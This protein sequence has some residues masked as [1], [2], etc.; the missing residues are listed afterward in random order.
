MK[1]ILKKISWLNIIIFLILGLIISGLCIIFRSP[2]TTTSTKDALKYWSDIT[3]IPAIIEYGIIALNFSAHHGTFD[4]LTY[5]F[6]YI[7]CKFIPM[8][9]IDEEISGTYADY[10]EIRKEKRKTIPYE[11]LIVATIFLIVAISCFIAY[12]QV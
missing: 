8:P 6:K 10:K 1:N 2:F 4:G 3:L 9:K 11:G 12:Y 5:S 7:A